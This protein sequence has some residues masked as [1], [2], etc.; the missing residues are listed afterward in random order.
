[1]TAG[2]CAAPRHGGEPYE[3]EQG[4]YL[5]REC[6]RRLRRDLCALPGLHADLEHVHNGAG[7]DGDETGVT[8]LD[9]RTHIKALLVSWTRLVAEERALAYPADTVPAIAAWLAAQCAAGRHGYCA[10]RPWSGD[11]A[12]EFADAR[13]TA[14]AILAPY[15]RK[16]PRI[17]AADRACP[18]CGEG[19]LVVRLYT[20]GGDRRWSFVGC[21]A[22]G[23][24]WE[25][26]QWWAELRP[27]VEARR[28]AAV[29]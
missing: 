15:E 29:T 27:L 21:A 26:W 16:A 17:P 19:E 4:A 8:A 22:C 18:V 23:A 3:A 11:M 1:V 12:G 5:C 14:L 20:S 7:P 13:L 25:L 9:H 24:R 10:M 28:E 2:W 6:R